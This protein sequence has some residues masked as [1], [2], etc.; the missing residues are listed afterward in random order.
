MFLPEKYTAWGC[1]TLY[2]DLQGTVS[3]GVPFPLPPELPLTVALVDRK[4]QLFLPSN[5]LTATGGC[6]RLSSRLVHVWYF[7]I[8]LLPCYKWIRS[9]AFWSLWNDLCRY[10]YGCIIL[11]ILKECIV[12]CTY[13]YVGLHVTCVSCR[14]CAAV[15]SGEY[16]LGSYGWVA[17]GGVTETSPQWG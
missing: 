4:I 11:Y 2:G 1:P 5:W 16:T 10:I 12:W 15:C 7:V 6:S 13:R 17:G 8:H 9:S 3:P 14:P